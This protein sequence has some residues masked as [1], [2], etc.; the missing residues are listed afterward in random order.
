MKPSLSVGYVALNSTSPQIISG[1]DRYDSYIVSNYPELQDG[2]PAAFIQVG[3]SVQPI[4]PGYFHVG[5]ASL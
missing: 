2:I 1:E 5:T 3:R 4:G